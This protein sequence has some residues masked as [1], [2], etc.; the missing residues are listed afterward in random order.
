MMAILLLFWWAIAA[1]QL[2]AQQT[3]KHPILAKTRAQREREVKQNEQCQGVSK[4]KTLKIK[5]DDGTASVKSN[6]WRGSRVLL[7][8]VITKAQQMSRTRRSA[9]RDPQLQLPVLWNLP[10]T[11]PQT[12]M[13][14][15]GFRLLILHFFENSRIFEN[16]H[17]FLQSEKITSKK[18]KKGK[19]W[20]REKKKKKKKKSTFHHI[21]GTLPGL[22]Q[23]WVSQGEWGTQI[24]K[25]KKKDFSALCIGEGSRNRPFQICDPGL[26]PT[27]GRGRK[28]KRVYFQTLPL[29]KNQCDFSFRFLFINKDESDKM[30]KT[31]KICKR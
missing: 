12:E 29:S 15:L 31:M 18:K 16:F 14:A 4:R 23:E 5:I 13:V 6:R 9:T 20:E 7:F 24:K 1:K 11:I 27:E 17:G 3:G 21:E 22:L 26:K 25:E 2:L 30:R 19:S 10:Q 8:L 28:S